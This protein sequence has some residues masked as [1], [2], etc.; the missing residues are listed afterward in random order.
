MALGVAEASREA[1]DADPVND[2]VRDEPHRARDDICPDIPLRRAWH[3]VWPATLARAE[4][5]AL[6]RRS[7]G[8]EADV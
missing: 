6:S 5:V 3:G 7:R 4:T 2:A 8:I 1:R